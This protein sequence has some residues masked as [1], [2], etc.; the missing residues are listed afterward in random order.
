MGTFLS[1]KEDEVETVRI[2][3]SLAKAKDIEEI[4]QIAGTVK[5]PGTDMFA[6]AS[7]LEAVVHGGVDVSDLTSPSLKRRG[8]LRGC[9][10]G[11]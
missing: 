1:G 2:I 10:Y 6:K 8:I 5:I 7:Y 11:V 4:R 9:G 3:S